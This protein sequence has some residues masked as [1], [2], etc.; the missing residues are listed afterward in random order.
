MFCLTNPPP[1]TAAR[2][3]PGASENPPKRTRGLLEKLSS[4]I[5]SEKNYS[6]SDD[7]ICYVNDFWVPLIYLR[8]SD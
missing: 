4:F 5:V 7:K 3:E 2:V 6:C 8:K 1:P